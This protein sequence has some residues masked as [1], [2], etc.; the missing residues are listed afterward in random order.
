MDRVPT[1]RHLWGTGPPVPVGHGRRC[2]TPPGTGPFASP[3]RAAP[4]SRPMSTI[5]RRLLVAVALV[6]VTVGVVAA[7][8]ASA[9]TTPVTIAAVPQPSVNAPSTPTN[10]SINLD[11]GGTKDGA[12]PS[13]SIVI[14]LLL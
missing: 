4:R 10:A 7:A 5:F 6:L 1:G 2:S 12:V 8:P 11:L 14:I 13:Q 3:D 9:Q